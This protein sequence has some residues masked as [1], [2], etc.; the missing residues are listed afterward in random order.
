MKTED[1]EDDLDVAIANYLSSGG[2]YRVAE[3]LSGADREMAIVVLGM[4]TKIRWEDRGRAPR[5]EVDLEPG[6]EYIKALGLPKITY[7]SCEQCNCRGI[8]LLIR[9]L[10]DGT[11]IESII[12]CNVCAE[13]K[14]QKYD[15]LKR[16]KSYEQDNPKGRKQYKPGWD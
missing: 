2:N 13:G 12:P 4:R 14:A 16:K 6:G 15:D 7:S 11:V 8:V 9:K 5:D 10:E 3:A 1:T